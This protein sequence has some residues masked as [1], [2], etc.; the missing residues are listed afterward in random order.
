MNDVKTIKDVLDELDISDGSR[1]L[2]IDR[3]IDELGITGTMEKFKSGNNKRRVYTQD[4]F[5]VIICWFRSNI[6]PNK[7]SRGRA[8]GHDYAV[9]RQNKNVKQIPQIAAN[10]E[11]GY[12]HSLTPK[13]GILKSKEV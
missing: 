11:R 5:D 6:K 3:I 2:T 13:G 4:E 10:R 9:I 12:Y 7:R 1:H 8:K